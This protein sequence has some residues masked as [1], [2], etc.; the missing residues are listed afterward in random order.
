MIDNDLSTKFLNFMEETIEFDVLITFK[1]PIE[2]FGYAIRSANDF[3]GRDP[4]KWS[5]KFNL[6]KAEG[7]T[8]TEPYY[9]VIH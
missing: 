4:R 6:P 9:E 1:R 8:E 2:I 3:P 5:V 7:S